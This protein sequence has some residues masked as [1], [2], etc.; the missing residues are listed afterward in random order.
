MCLC[1]KSK[2]PSIQPDLSDIQYI[3]IIE[4]ISGTGIVHL[5]LEF[6]LRVHVYITNFVN[7]NNRF[8]FEPRFEK[9]WLLGCRPGPIQ[10]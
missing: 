10:T 3:Y 7:D 8:Y 4:F 2:G 9:T 5:T 6:L 1:I